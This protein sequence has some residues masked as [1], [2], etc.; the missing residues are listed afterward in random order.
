MRERRARRA[1]LV[2]LD[3]A[4][5]V[6]VVIL[7]VL[8]AARVVGDWS[9]RTVLSGSMSPAIER[10]DIVVASPTSVDDVAVGDVIQF[11]A[12]DSG[13]ITVHRVESTEA[14]GDSV[15][16]GTKGDANDRPD[17]WQLKI[18]DADVHEV[19]AVLPGLGGVVRWMS[20]PLPRTIVG[21]VSALAVLSLGL[22]TIWG[23]PGGTRPGR[24]GGGA[25]HPGGV[26]RPIRR[27][28]GRSRHGGPAAGSAGSRT[29]LGR[30]T[31]AALTAGA[32]I[33]GSVAFDA[34]TA[35]ATFVPA[36]SASASVATGVPG[37]PADPRCSW[38]SAT[39]LTFDWDVVSTGIETSTRL[40]R[41][42][43]SGG[44]TTTAA[45]TTPVSVATSTITAPTPVTTPRFYTLRTLRN[46]WTSAPS[47]ELRSD[48]CS[49]AIT[50]FAGNGTAGFSGDA[51]A[52]TAARLN[53]PRGIA[54]T[55]SGTTYVADAANNRIRAVS[56]SG[57]I[58]TFAGGPAASAC[59]Y[60]GPVSGL[61]LNAPRG[62]AVDSTGNVYVADTGA[63]CVR[64]IDTAGNVT[65]VA[66][67][68]AT[69]SCN[70]TGTATAVSLS[71]PSGVEVG[72]SGAVYIADTGRNCV[73]KV[74]G[75]TYSHVAGGGSTTTCNSTGAS[76]AVSLSGPLDVT[77]DASETVYVADTG[78]N[79]I[80]KV[81]GTTYSLVAGGGATTTCTST[82]AA[83]SVSLSAP[84]S[85]AVDSAGVVYLSDTGRRCIRRAVG[86]TVSQV[87][88]TGT[89]SAIGDGGPVVA[90]TIRTPAGLALDADGGLLVSDRATNAGCSRVRRVVL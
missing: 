66:G 72:P 8:T 44:A 65:R 60:T 18:D 86:S 73:R 2:G 61:G 21:I 24:S 52:A 11:A 81:V 54:A 83:S 4:I 70:S 85:V 28:V 90:A 46:S 32:V 34:G 62:V 3:A 89:N 57:T 40:L 84:E 26:R 43:T 80:R 75:T 22:L 1:G 33:A 17:P 49:G 5:A 31:V 15:V 76:T 37:V 29:H 79:C 48:G 42:D 19:R 64:R 14:H 38:A 47:T 51:G 39:T 20:S 55:A 13:E 41:S 45:T 23:R 10:G 6:S 9:V 67:G 7:V 58:T 25:D 74:V 77:V 88:F 71:N 63:A 50:A 12:P 53:Q 27:R 30:G 16:F 68:G 82:V 59:S 69:T 35:E 36:A 87:G 56:P 78:R